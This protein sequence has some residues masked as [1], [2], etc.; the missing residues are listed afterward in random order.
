[1][2]DNALLFLLFLIAL[3]LVFGVAGFIAEK[4]GRK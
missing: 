3:C 2:S 1:V 4:W